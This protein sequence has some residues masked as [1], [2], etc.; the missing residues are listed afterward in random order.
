M[1]APSRATQSVKDGGEASVG[2]CIGQPLSLVKIHWAPTPLRRRKATRTGTA[3]RAPGRPGV[4][5]EPGM[6]R[7][8]LRGNREITRLTR[9]NKESW[10]A[11]GRRGAVADHV[12]VRDVRL[13]H[14]S[15]EADEQSGAIRCVVGGAKGGGQGEY[16]SAKH[17]PGAG[18]GKR[19]TGAVPHTASGKAQEEGEVHRALPP[20]SLSSCSG[21]R[22]SNS[23]RMP[24]P[25]WT[26]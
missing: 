4:V 2:E 5:E 20:L 3:T 24:L 17:V 9:G 25:E 23:R 7:S 8:S 1:S 10:F 21:R 26:G 16:G 22:S 12:R 18:P 19:V 13:R 6:C 14:I 11:S 15:W